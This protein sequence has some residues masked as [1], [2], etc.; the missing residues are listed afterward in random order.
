[1]FVVMLDRFSGAKKILL[2][3]PLAKGDVLRARFFP[4][5]EKEGL[6]EIF[7]CSNRQRIGP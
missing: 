2:D 6:G 5:F 1:M 3:P 4:L 7:D